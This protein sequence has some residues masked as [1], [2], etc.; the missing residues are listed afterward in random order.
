MKTILIIFLSET[1]RQIIKSE[2]ELSRKTCYKIACDITKS[3]EPYFIIQ[4]N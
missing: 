3:I 1:S 2:Q 4:R